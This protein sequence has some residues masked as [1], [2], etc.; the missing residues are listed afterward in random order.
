MSLSF[1]GFSRTKINE[2]KLQIEAI[3]EGFIQM[4]SDLEAEQRSMRGIWKKREKQID[5]VLLNTAG[6]YGSVKGIVSSAIQS[7]PLLELPA[8]DEID[9][10]I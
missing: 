6:M 2:F 8:H 4:K 5:K 3:V 10:D 9:V 7:V 1:S